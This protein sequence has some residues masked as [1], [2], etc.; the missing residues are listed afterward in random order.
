MIALSPEE[1]ASLCSGQDFWQT[2]AIARLGIPAVFLADGPHGLRKPAGDPQQADI[3][4]VPA[5][6]FPTASAL[7]NSWDRELLR[8]IGKALA[9]ECRAHGVGMLLG[10]GINI[11]RSPLCGRNFEYF[12]EDPLLGGELAAAWILSLIHI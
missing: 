4:G 1:K 3:R 12:S 2:Q 7:A 5:T 9:T 6:C 11:K 10:P 8:S